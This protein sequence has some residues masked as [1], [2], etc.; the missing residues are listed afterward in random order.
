LVKVTVTAALV[1]YLACIGVILRD[2]VKPYRLVARNFYGRLAVFDDA[3]PGEDEEAARHLVHGVINHGEQ[4]LRKQYSRMPITYFCPSS[5]IGIAMRA[6]EGLP[7]KL[8]IIGLGCGTLA[9]YGLPG[10][11]IRIYEINPLVLHFAQNQFT[12]LRDTA[13]RT[14]LVMGDG[15]LSLER[16]ASQNFDLLVMDAFSGDSVPVHLITREA[17]RT[18]LRHL[19]PDG[20]L[21]VNISNR[22]LDFRPVIERGASAFGKMAIVF[23]YTP[24]D[25]DFMC[26]SSSWILVM[27]ASARRRLPGHSG[28][29]LES[30]ASFRPWT[31]DFSN[32]QRILK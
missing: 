4:A 5:G 29:V 23:D 18:Y 13:A 15:R 26:F 14:E 28:Q 32:M 25:D 1:A 6:L 20:I 7:R 2:A 9:A 30:N 8:G 16:E 22:Y 12:Y 19:K 3:D 21:A 17:F 27:D 11:I 31:D 24:A 10:D